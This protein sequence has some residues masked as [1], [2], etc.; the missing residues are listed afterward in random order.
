MYYLL[1]NPPT[2]LDVI[3]TYLPTYLPTY[4][5]VLPT[6]LPIHSLITYLNINYLPTYPHARHTKNKLGLIPST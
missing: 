3:F 6:Y 2:Y 4:L 1:T 5:D